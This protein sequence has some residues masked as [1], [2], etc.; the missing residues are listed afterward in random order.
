MPGQSN[1]KIGKL[2]NYF[3][4]LMSEDGIWKIP[5]LYDNCKLYTQVPE[6]AKYEEN[7]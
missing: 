3:K 7:V 4:V 1:N 5:T 6:I 2:N